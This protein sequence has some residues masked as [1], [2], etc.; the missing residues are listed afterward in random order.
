MSPKSRKSRNQRI[1]FEEGNWCCA[2]FGVMSACFAYGLAAGDPIKAITMKHGTP[3]VAGIAGSDG[4][5][6]RWIH[7][8][9]HLVRDCE[10]RNQDRPP[11]LYL[12]FAQATLV[13]VSVTIVGDRTGCAE[14]GNGGG[15]PV[16]E[17]AFQRQ[18][19]VAVDSAPAF[20]DQ[21][22]CVCRC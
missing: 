2:S 9:F 21:P 17:A 16:R 1:R 22:R 11:V 7:H 12:D 18:S 5:A 20:K 19:S 4:G 13:E 3:A 10:Y 6:G 15:H 8:Q 14:P